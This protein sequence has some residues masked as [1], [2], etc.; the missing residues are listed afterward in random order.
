M[1]VSKAKEALAE[2]LRGKTPEARMQ[3]FRDIQ[4]HPDYVAMQRLSD[5]LVQA[6]LSPEVR[7]SA[8]M[9]S[10]V[11]LVRETLAEFVPGTELGDLVEPLRRLLADHGGGRPPKTDPAAVM[12]KQTALEAAWHPSPQKEAAK[13]YGITDRTVRNYAKSTKK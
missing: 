4:Q 9:S 1:P 10:F 11:F 6:H 2:H 8:V 3:V 7:A 5:A 12:K 13:L